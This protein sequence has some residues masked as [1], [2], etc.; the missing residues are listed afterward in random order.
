[1][2]LIHSAESLRHGSRRN[3]RPPAARKG[4]PSG[5]ADFFERL[6]A[7]G[8]ESGADDLHALH[9]FGAEHGSVA[10]VAGPSHSA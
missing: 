4:L 3:A 1:M 8:N 5:D 2:A 10:S 9:A 6:E 7:V